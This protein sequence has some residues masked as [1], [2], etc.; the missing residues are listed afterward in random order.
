MRLRKTLASIAVFALT[1]LGMVAPAAAALTAGS[2]TIDE[3]IATGGEILEGA[4]GAVHFK[5]GT[6]N[7]NGSRPAIAISSDPVDLTEAGNFQATFV[8]LS[9]TQDSRFGYYLGYS[10]PTKGLFIG[11]DSGGWF[12]QRYG[13]DGQWLAN[14]TQAAPQP[15]KVTNIDISWD[16]KQATLTVDG[17]KAF[18]VDYSGMASVLTN[19]LAMKAG[20][21]NGAMTEVVVADPAAVTP[22]EPEEESSDALVMP[23]IEDKLEITDGDV[24]AYLYKEF[25]QVAVYDVDG[26]QL[27]GHV[28]DV[29]TAVKVNEVEYGVTA[30]EGVVAEDGASATYKVTIADLGADFTVRISLEDGTLTWVVTEI[31]DP[32][33][34]IDR[35]AIPNLDLVT[36]D[37]TKAGA[38]T[39]A[40]NTTSRT[41]SSDKTIDVATANA[42]TSGNGWFAAINNNELAAGLISNA[43]ADDENSGADGSDVKHRWLGKVAEYDGAKIGTISPGSWVI[44]GTSARGEGK[45]GAEIMPYAQVRVVADVNDDAK[46]DWQ[47][48]AT[49]TRDIMVSNG[50]PNGY[51][52]TANNVIERIPFNIVSQAT[53]PFLRTLDD[54]KRISLATDNLGQN[55]LLKGYQAEGH[56]SAQGDYGSHYNDRAGGFDDLVTMLEASRDYN[57]HYGVHVNA[58]E[59]YSEA[60]CFSD[61]QHEPAG[62]GA[63]YENPCEL[64]MP[65]SA[66][67]GWM[68]QAYYMN[69]VKDLTTKNVVDRFQNFR[70]ELTAAGVA[71]ELDWLYFDVYYRTGWIGHRLSEEMQKQGWRVGSEWAYSMPDYSLWS[72]WANDEN[73][74]GTTNKGINSPLVR[75]IQNSWRDTWNP[76]PLLGNPNTKEF[77]GWTGQTDYNNFI[78]NVWQRNLPAKFLQQSDI[79]TYELGSKATFE[80][81]TEVTS[82]RTSVSGT[83]L[84]LDRVI[85]YDGK[86]VYTGGAYLLPWGESEGIGDATAAKMYH[87]NQNGGTT[88]WQLTGAF[89]N[90]PSFTLYELTDTGRAN[91]VTVANNGGE[92]SLN[93]QANTAYVLYPNEAPT[94]ADP[95]WGEG[96]HI[97]DPGFYA[98]D[99]AAEGYV[100]TGDATVNTNYTANGGRNL[101]RVA[102]IGAGAGSIAQTLTLPAG[103]YSMWAWVEIQAGK[104]RPVSVSVS[105]DASAIGNQ[106][107]IDG[108]PTTNIT[109][110]T[111]LNATA[112]D[113]KLR[114]YFQRVRV[115]FHTDGGDVTFKVAAG[116]GDALIRVDDLRVVK[117]VAPVDPAPTAETVFFDDFESVDTGYWPFVTGIAEV[118][119]DA[120][121]Q[122]AENHPPYSNAGWYGK[123][124]SGTV[125][126]GGKLTDNVLEGNWSLLAH[127][128]NGGL[129]LRTTQASVPFDSGKTYRVS[130][131]F[132][133]A[134]E[135][136]YELVLGRDRVTGTEVSSSQIQKLPFPAAR[137]TGVGGSGTQTLSVEFTT[138]T[139]GNYWIGVNKVGGTTGSDLTLDNFRVELIDDS[140]ETLPGNATP[141]VV[142]QTSPISEGKSTVVHGW[143]EFFESGTPTNITTTLLAPEGWGVAVQ[144]ERDSVANDLDEY[145]D[146]TVPVGASDGVVTYTVT[147]DVDNDGVFREVTQTAK[148]KVVRGIRPG[149]NYLSD[150]PW[151]DESNGWGPVE[152][153]QENGEQGLNDGTPITMGG[154]EY[155]KGLG[156]HSQSGAA[157]ANLTFDLTNAQCT[158]LRAVVGMNDTQPK[159]DV[160]FS[161]LGDGQSMYESGTVTK[162]S[163][164]QIVDIDIT[165]INTLQLQV[166][167]AN[168]SNGNDHANWGNAR[169]ICG[170]FSVSVPDTES[171]AGENVEIPVAVSG[172]D[173]VEP[174]EVTLT[175]A[176]EGLVFNPATGAIEGTV[177]SVFDGDVTVTL[178]QG[179]GEPATTTFHLTVTKSE[180]PVEPG[181]PTQP[182]GAT[183]PGE[184][185]GTTGPGEPGEPGEPELT[186]P[187]NLPLVPTV[188]VPVNDA[189]GSNLATTGANTGWATVVSVLFVAAGLALVT[190]RRHA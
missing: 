74:G 42:G 79:K 14:R 80:N 151:T 81:G 73:Y 98:G 86:T 4:E 114:T 169:L 16:G 186:A 185:G 94:Q 3:N 112:S 56:D 152:R 38:M 154:V 92:V 123:N 84:G 63:N 102:E 1:L 61:G 129:I 49:A 127:E 138:G 6:A 26:A 175:G 13:G 52:D 140:P 132:Q 62:E 37:S 28:G 90:V 156:M 183:E 22:E 30:S 122:M 126:E 120:R 150:L 93:A 50:L 144:G 5:S 180:E 58:T 96:T 45:I 188:P 119:G 9:S 89:A 148:I 171:T 19:T 39:F 97:S 160:T 32:N 65:P 35:L 121:T 159:G 21:Y 24:T 51:E 124:A 118:G 143:T 8:Q 15:G 99:L 131:D 108:V 157:V 153:D 41:T 173:T 36:V 184:P 66:G 139:E 34:K 106:V 116:D 67:W 10:N 7:D 135:G 78:N 25:P 187:G 27:A 170:E 105:G 68:N 95:Q 133:N 88:S 47:D 18:D 115:T 141:N 189:S 147:Y 163:G 167:N 155:A 29:A 33:A 162:E 142:V 17:N 178:K 71:D 158:A 55:V 100:T 20:T 149:T 117:Y 57:A 168:G 48:S 190:R 87:Y 60:Q 31:N 59:S 75:F 2:W 137:G 76:D 109:M 85:T 44:Y 161:V 23:S 77:E 181:Q 174:F 176:P 145:W 101:G 43:I 53:H 91:P 164:T 130:V 128:E 172:V 134:Y 125:V 72:H 110:S 166:G 113:E 46:V 40:V 12:W 111:A 54:T 64:Q 182:G 83:D 177:A 179:D 136:E 165:G 70:D 146:V 82:S 104:E 103:D 69:S 11:Y 107:A